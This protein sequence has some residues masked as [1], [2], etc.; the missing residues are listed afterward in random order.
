VDLSHESLESIPDKQTAMPKSV[1]LI[2]MRGSGKTF[3]G[4][5]AAST[6]SWPR[7][8]ADE[9]FET[10]KQIGVREFVHQYGF[11][12]FRVV[13]T[14]IL[15]ELL[16]QQSARS[17]SLGGGVVQAPAARELLKEYMRK[18]GVVVHLMRPIDEVVRFLENENARPDYGEPIEDVFRRREPWYKECSNYELAN[19]SGSLTPSTRASWDHISKFFRHVTGVQANVVP[20]IASGKRSYFLSLTYP[21][22]T[23]ALPQ[24]EQLTA[25]VDAL[26]LRVDLLRSPDHVCD[27][28]VPY[29]PPLAY[30]A[31]QLTALQRSTPLPIIFTVRTVSQGGAFPDTAEKEAFEL[32]ELAL[33]RGVEYIDVEISWPKQ[34]IIALSARKGSSQII[35]SWHDWSGRM[36]WDSLLVKEKYDLATELGDIVKIVGKANNIRDNFKL[37]EFVYRVNASSSSKP[38]IAINMGEEGQLSRILNIT[39]TPVTHPLLP[40]KAAPGQLSLAQINSALHLIGSLP[41]L[42]FF[43]FGNPIAASMSPT[44]HNTGFEVL[45]LPH[46]YDLLETSSVGKEIKSAIMSADFGGASVTI[47]FKLDIIP[48]LDELS[49]AAKAIGAVNTIIPVPKSP[50]SADGSRNVLLYGDNTDW[51]GICEVIRANQPPPGS[52]DALNP[53]SALAALVI[54]AGGTARAAVYALHELGA[55]TVYLY[56]RTRSKAEALVGAFP[57]VNLVV[58]DALGDKEGLS[59]LPDGAVQPSIIVSTVPASALTAIASID[60]NDE[61]LRISNQMFGVEGGVVVDM[62]YRPAE[63]DLLKLAKGV[64]GG[65]WKAVQGLEVLLEQGYVQFERWTGRRCP[66]TEVRKRVL[67]KYGI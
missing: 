8:D 20:D 45:G 44:L 6:L 53:S 41:S 47:P 66:R 34:Q 55:R 4:S 1:V 35:T 9:Y 52:T 39:L 50:N 10:Q 17:I 51:L 62:A 2:G 15:Q 26:E 12:A 42:K 48:L 3:T 61:R 25:G 46:V 7:V 37:Q 31:D 18:G 59:W 54:G 21:D 24:L 63:T 11:P 14:A 38:I 29:I 67:E 64:P 16:A 28:S 40:T 56:N 49:P 19:S 32:F 33:R 27:I 5:L 43:L 65:R 30:V 23:Q 58:L 60:G 13:E 57:N 22:V 36:E